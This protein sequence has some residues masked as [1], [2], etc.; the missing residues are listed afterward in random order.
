MYRCTAG[1]DIRMSVHAYPNTVSQLNATIR[2][3]RANASKES[4]PS[5]VWHAIG[6]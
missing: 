1:V 6:Y 3:T 2:L 5:V 4:N